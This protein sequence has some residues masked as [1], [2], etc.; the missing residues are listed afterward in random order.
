[1]SLSQA[2]S[3]LEYDDFLRVYF[4]CGIKANEQARTVC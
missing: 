1:M 4:S 2:P 3:V